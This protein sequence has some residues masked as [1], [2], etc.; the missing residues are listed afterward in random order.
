MKQLTFALS[1]RHDLPT[2]RADKRRNVLAC[3]L[4]YHVAGRVIDDIHVDEFRLNYGDSLAN[5]RD[6]IQ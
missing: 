4:V 2:T 1:H 3:Y 5:E 6:I